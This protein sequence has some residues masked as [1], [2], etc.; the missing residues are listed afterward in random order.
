MHHTRHKHSVSRGSLRRTL[1]PRPRLQLSACH[2]PSL[3]Q[4]PDHNCPATDDTSSRQHY[5]PSCSYCRRQPLALK[6]QNAIGFHLCEGWTEIDLQTLVPSGQI[7][8]N[9]CR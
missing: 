9:A 8:W 6:E 7:T 5:V 3:V 1:F 2:A 4:L